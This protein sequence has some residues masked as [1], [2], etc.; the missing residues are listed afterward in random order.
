MLNERHQNSRKMRRAKA[1]WHVQLGRH[2]RHSAAASAL[3]RRHCGFQC[4]HLGVDQDLSSLACWP[5]GNYYRPKR[6]TKMMLNII[7]SLSVS[8]EEGRNGVVTSIFKHHVCN[9]PFK[10]CKADSRP[11]MLWEEICAQKK[12]AQSW[13]LSLY[14]SVVSAWHTKRVLPSNV[15][16]VTHRLLDGGMETIDKLGAPSGGLAHN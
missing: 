10:C 12:T 7:I 14:P 1:W 4:N 16:M 9:R 3:I 2:W 8:R 15:S 5:S 13:Q 11:W 6:R